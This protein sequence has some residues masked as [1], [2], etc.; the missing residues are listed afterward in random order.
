MCGINLGEF[1][2]TVKSESM[3]AKF[4]SSMSMLCENVWGNNAQ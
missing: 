3:E 4:I 1:E 2:I